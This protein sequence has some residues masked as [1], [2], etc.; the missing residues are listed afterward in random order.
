[1]NDVAQALESV[2][3]FIRRFIVMDD[4][5]A[6]GVTLW[7]FHTHV[8]DAADY[9]PYL[10]VTSAERESGKSR[11]KE[12]VELLVLNPIPTSN[13]SPAALFRM[14]SPEDGPPATFLVDELDEIFS[15][16]SE[17]SELRGLL[18]AGFHRGDFAIRMVGEGT[19][20]FPQ[21]FHVF[22]AKLLAGKNSAAL[23]DTLESR[24]IR[25]ELKRK[26]RD[27]LVDRFRRREVEDVALYIAETL[28]SLGAFYVDGLAL[29]RP[30]LPDELSDRQ[31]DV[32]EPLL[33]I[34]ELAGGGWADRAR[35]AA[36]SLSIGREDDESLGVR[37]LADVR[38]VF[39]GA[40]RVS[41]ARLIELLCLIE[42][43]PWSEK[44]W[45][46]FKGEPKGGAASNLAWHL[47]RYNIRSKTIR[48]D[49]GLAKG[50]ERAHFEDGWRRYLPALGDLARNRRD[51]PHEYRDSD[52]F[53]TRN[54][55]PLVTARKETSN[56]HKPSGVTAVTAETAQEGAADIPPLGEDGF[57]AFLRASYEAGHLTRREVGVRVRLHERVRQAR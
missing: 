46:S 1:M 3:G 2:H 11:L 8:L 55:T 28:R 17:R 20:Q 32:W 31:Q 23:G 57:A 36:V 26:N 45:D 9:T 49:T 10:L 39:D 7:V 15:P 5:Q 43:A 44:W 56:P 54:M 41:T 52:P 51:T 38:Q 27:E 4:A 25:I 53:A 21:Q 12:A 19:K 37:L 42:E 29:A 30:V 50:Y 6:I 47:R 18:N 48:F 14:A 35:T 40:E 22:C 34:A 24:C 33:A 13:V 16:K